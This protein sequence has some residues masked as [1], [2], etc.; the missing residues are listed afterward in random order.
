VGDSMFAGMQF[1]DELIQKVL[2]CAAADRLTYA[3]AFQRWV[4]LDPHTCTLDKLAQAAHQHGLQDAPPW[5]PDDRD[6]WLDWLLVTC[7]EPRLGDRC[8][9]LL[10]DYPASQAALA[11][12]RTDP[13]PGCPSVSSYI[14]T[15]SNWPMVITS[16]PIR[17]N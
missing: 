15:A 13:V 9:T 6:A 7:V 4:G 8:P 14:S 10:Y 5:A 12:V 1:L 11:R 2:G 17:T 3:A 16:S